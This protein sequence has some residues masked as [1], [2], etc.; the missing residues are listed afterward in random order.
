M[1]NKQINTNQMNV[2]LFWYDT[3]DLYY[4]IKTTN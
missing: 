3:F 2:W 1:S 4:V